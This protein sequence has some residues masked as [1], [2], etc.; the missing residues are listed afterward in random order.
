MANVNKL[1]DKGQ[2]Y[3]QKGKYESAVDAFNQVVKL[4]PDDEE[5]LEILS[6]LYIRLKKPAESVRCLTRAADVYQKTNQPPKVIATYRKIVKIAPRDTRSL[7]KLAGVLERSRKAIDALEIYRQ[8]AKIF[9]AAKNSEQAYDCYQK[10]VDLDLDKLEDRIQLGE[11]A[12]QQQQPVEAASAFLRAG[13][14]AKKAGD[15]DQC[16][17]LLERSHELDPKVESTRLGLAEAYSRRGR[18][19]DVIRLLDSLPAEKRESESVLQILAESYLETQ[20][21]DKAEPICLKLYQKKPE[22]LPLLVKLIGGWIK[23]GQTDKVEKLLGSLKETFFRQGKR[24]EYAKIVEQAYAA[25]ET[26][27]PLLTLLSDLYN[28]LSQDDKY[29]M[30]LVR[31]FT[32]YLGGE[33][34]K[35]AADILESM[36]DLDPYEGEMQNRLLSLE[37]HLDPEFY[38]SIASRLRQT[39]GSTVDETLVQ[40]GKEPVGEVELLD[41]LLLEAEIFAQ[42]QLT[43]KVKDQLEKINKLHPG[44]EESNPRLKELYES[45]GFTPSQPEAAPTPSPATPAS[46]KAAEKVPEP[47]APVE[48]LDDLKKVTALVGNIYR[49]VSPQGVLKRSVE[50]IGKWLR[51]SRCWGALGSP[52]GAPNITREYCSAT[53]QASD[54]KAALKLHAVLRKQVA[55]KPDGWSVDDVAKEAPLSAVK[56]ELQTLGIRSLLALP[57]LEGDQ[58]VGLIVLE[59]CENPRPWKPNEGLLLRTL[60]SQ[61]AIAL[62]TTKLR[63]LVRTLAGTD[64]ST[65]FLPRSAYLDC[66]MA[67]VS[68]AKDQDT[69]VSVSLFELDKGAALYGK[70]GDKGLQEL[71]EAVG[72]AIL[73]SIRQ[74]DITIRYSPYSIALIFPDTPLEP[75]AR[76]AEKLRA[77]MTRIRMAGKPVSYCSAVAEVR[78]GENFEPADGVTELINRI[79]GALVMAQKK[80]GNRTVI[81]KFS[82]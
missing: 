51:V 18:P 29:R 54:A 49:E 36:I 19:Q 57:L 24:A 71:M 62:N 82:S 12:I 55:A 34:Y 10:I 31:L 45:I 26:N 41:D 63:R 79:E 11:L 58:P 4:E 60:G 48:S 69:C 77:G 59:A 6:D 74:T 3:L 70:V 14:L 72:K 81:S 40:A 44:A 42:Y 2:K 68:R 39:L 38:K 33:A 37:G 61:I 43:G 27:I 73:G 16:L 15:E 56:K 7:L 64:S 21:L 32:H 28:E 22:S 20:D 8:A 9:L 47:A 35:K 23:S 52:D 80:G 5:T 66:L 75:A 17:H 67:E 76:V 13:N 50:E 65:G 78:L 1:F 46:K 53:T 25:D 30:T